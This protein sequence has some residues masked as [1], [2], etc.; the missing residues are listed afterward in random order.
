MHKKEPWEWWLIAGF[1]F[2][3]L[4]VLAGAYYCYSRTHWDISVSVNMTQP[5]GQIFDILTSPE[6]RVTWQYG[7][8]AV[9]PLVGDDNQ[10]GSTRFIF[11]RADR[12]SWQMEETLLVYEKPLRWHVRQ[13]SDDKVTDIHFEIEHS[14][15]VSHVTWNETHSFANPWDKVRAFFI[16][17]AQ[18]ARILKGLEQASRIL[19]DGRPA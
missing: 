15:N 6:G 7:V 9:T 1:S 8:T 12:K 19:A 17:R 16:I 4:A 3:C 11:F 13:S 18:K 5:P 10:I 14:S 2:L